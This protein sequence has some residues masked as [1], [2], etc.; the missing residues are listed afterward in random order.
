MVPWEKVT[1]NEIVNFAGMPRALPKGI[2][3]EAG[4]ARTAHTV[5]QKDLC[6]EHEK[7]LFA[8]LVHENKLSQAPLAIGCKHPRCT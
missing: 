3:L 1:E 8:R 4:T 5:Q 6:G 7:K 2:R